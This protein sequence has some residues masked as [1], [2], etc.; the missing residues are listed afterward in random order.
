M[1]ILLD[2]NILVRAASG[3][4]SPAEELLRLCLAPPHV[5]CLSPFLLSEV[6]R[7]LRYPRVQKVHGMSDEKID[8]YLGFLRA[9]SLM[10]TVPS[11]AV[12]TV[13]PNDPKDDPIVATAV[14]AKAE[15]ICTLDRHLHHE[16]VVLYCDSRKI[17]VVTDIELLHRL[18]PAAP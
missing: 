3:P 18:R 16:A 11:D 8:A 15:A 17:E 13:V 7:V 4:P 9:G 6:S 1:R 10:V 2:T 14:A 5:L 12:E